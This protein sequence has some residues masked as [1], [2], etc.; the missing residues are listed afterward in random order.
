MA[1][2]DDCASVVSNAWKANQVPVEDIKTCTS[3]V[4]T[5]LLKWNKEEFDNIDRN[6]ANLEN[7]LKL[8]NEEPPNV[9]T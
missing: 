7:H 3:E 5:R 4:C 1:R 9:C 2:H 8:L 6:L